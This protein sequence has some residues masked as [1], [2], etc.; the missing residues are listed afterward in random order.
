MLGAQNKPPEQMLRRGLS[1]A[2]PDLVGWGCASGACDRSCFVLWI[3][4]A[5]SVCQHIRQRIA[6]LRGTGPFLA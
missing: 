1:F 4:D 5:F 2:M 3:T 6:L